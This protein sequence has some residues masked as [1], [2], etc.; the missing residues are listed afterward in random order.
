MIREYGG[1][2]GVG[3]ITQTLSLFLLFLSP[4]SFSSCKYFKPT[5]DAPS[6]LNCSFNCALHLHHTEVKIFR[7]YCKNI[8]HETSELIFIRIYFTT[9]SK[10]SAS[11]TFNASLWRKIVI[12]E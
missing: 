2:T 3:M 12:D 7:S 6:V 11:L 10:Y 4:H 5:L 1:V 9:L 8:K